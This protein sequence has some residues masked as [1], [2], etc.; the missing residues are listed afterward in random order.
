MTALATAEE[1]RVRVGAGVFS[2]ADTDRAEA[3]LEDVSAEVLHITGADWD[4]DDVP[5]VVRTVVLAAAKRIWVN[6]SGLEYEQAGDY[7]W[8]AAAADGLL[9]ATEVGRVLEAVGD[10]SVGSITT[11]L[12]DDHIINRQIVDDEVWW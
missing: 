4:V 2:D 11:P 5:S 9:T 12:P 10:F 1:L 7:S 3:A 8:R 6:P